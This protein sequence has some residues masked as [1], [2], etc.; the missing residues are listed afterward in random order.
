MNIEEVKQAKTQEEA[1]QY[2]IE[3]QHWMITST[4]WTWIDLA[5]WGNVFEFLAEKFNLVEEFTENGII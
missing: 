2:A 1:R 4:D 5:E 3:Y